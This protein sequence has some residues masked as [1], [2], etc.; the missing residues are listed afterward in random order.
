[1]SLLLISTCF[2]PVYS[3]AF[4][5]ARPP[6]CEYRGCVYSTLLLMPGLPAAAWHSQSLALLF[7]CRK[8]F[9]I[10]HDKPLKEMALQR[11]SPVRVQE[12]CPFLWTLIKWM[13]STTVCRAAWR[14][15]AAALRERERGRGTRYACIID[16]RQ[17]R[18][19]LDD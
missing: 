11:H 1:M 12:M 18:D 15:L 19:R 13:K 10:V 17:L 3:A 7:H 14:T 6:T 2:I 9:C 5:R 16:S 8:R 4:A